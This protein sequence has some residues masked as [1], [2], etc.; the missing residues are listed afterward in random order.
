MS[1][2]TN[3][4]YV[5]E[6]LNDNGYDYGIT[7]DGEGM[8]WYESK[9]EAVADLPEHHYEHFFSTPRQF[10]DFRYGPV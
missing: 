6:R 5:V 8:Y 9:A 7:P 3:T 2:K 1:I 10:D 4:L